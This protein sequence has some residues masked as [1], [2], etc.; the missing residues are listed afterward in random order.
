MKYQLLFVFCII[1]FATST[2]HTVEANP[3]VES[4]L[5]D[6]IWLLQNPSLNNALVV[7]KR[8]GWSPVAPY[9]AGV[10][11]MQAHDDYEKGLVPSGETEDQYYQYMMGNITAMITALGNSTAQVAF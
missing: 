1:F 7:L 2:V 9:V 11:R 4:T 6:L 10:V 5:N 8:N 3:I